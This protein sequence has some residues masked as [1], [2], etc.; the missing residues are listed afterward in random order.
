MTTDDE[1]RAVT[2]VTRRLSTR[3]PDVPVDVVS[4]TVHHCHAQFAGSPIRDFVLV[5]VERIARSS[6]LAGTAT[7]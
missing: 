5:L 6:L 1:A 4:A 3:F 2:E 7:R